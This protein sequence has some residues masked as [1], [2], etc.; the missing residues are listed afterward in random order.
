[1]W[2]WNLSCFTWIGSSFLM[3]TLQL[4]RKLIS[5]LF[6]LGLGI[7]TKFRLPPECWASSLEQIFV[8]ESFGSFTDER[9]GFFPESQFG[10]FYTSLHSHTCN[11][12][13]SSPGLWRAQVEHS[14]GRRGSFTCWTSRPVGKVNIVY[15]LEISKRSLGDLILGHECQIGTLQINFW[16]LPSQQK[17]A[18]SISHRT[19]WR[20]PLCKGHGSGWGCRV[21]SSDEW[22]RQKSVL[23]SE[24]NLLGFH[25]D[26]M[27]VVGSL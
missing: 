27:I 11:F 12:F 25:F 8:F 9:W 10:L 17:G 6:F 26:T 1:M 24:D 22:K 16:I 4:F 5:F 3:V 14:N 18:F 15:R 20:D 7:F 2:K 23:H 19:V 13:C 21:L